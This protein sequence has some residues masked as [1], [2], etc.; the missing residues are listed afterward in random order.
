MRVLEMH[1]LETCLST[2]VSSLVKHFFQNFYLN[3]MRAL[4]H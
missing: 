1:V 2:A 3:S 4:V